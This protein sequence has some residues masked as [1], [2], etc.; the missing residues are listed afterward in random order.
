[1]DGN[2]C[3][4]AGLVVWLS[5]DR[6]LRKRRLRRAAPDP[7]RR[8]FG[9]AEMWELDDHLNQIAEME[10]H[11]LDATVA[12]YVAG[13]AG[14]VVKISDSPEGLALG[15]SDGWRLVLGTVSRSKL[16]ALRLRAGETRLYPA[17]FERR[18][19]F[20][21]LVLRG[22]TGADVELTTRRVALAH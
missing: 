13:V 6:L 15:L 18:T 12:R 1:M 17:R 21:R 20:Y 10:Q 14:H 8:V 22:E 11:R 7:L 9:P 5:G 2:L 3:F 16:D 4:A 19:S